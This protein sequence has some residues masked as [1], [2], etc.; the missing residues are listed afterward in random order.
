MKAFFER[1]TTRYLNADHIPKIRRILTV[2]AAASE[3]G[4]M[5]LPGFG[6]HPLKGDYENYFAVS[7]SGNWR[8]IFRFENEDAADVELIDYH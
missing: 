4:D 5:G 2:L 7:V 1:G 6:L 8:I 3:P